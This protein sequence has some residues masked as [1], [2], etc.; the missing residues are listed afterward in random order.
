M[1]IIP[2]WH[3][4]SNL[5]SFRCSKYMVIPN[6]TTIFSSVIAEQNQATKVIVGSLWKTPRALSTS[7]FDCVWD[8]APKGNVCINNSCSSSLSPRWKQEQQWIC[9]NKPFRM[10]H[11]HTNCGAKP[12]NEER[13]VFSQYCCCVGGM[14]WK[15]EYCTKSPAS[16][17][18]ALG[19]QINTQIQYLRLCY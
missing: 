12:V 16:L 5:D 15:Q 6:I 1:Y 2:S 14:V 17:V 8:W 19:F 3:F 10:I 13:G 9:E 7:V 18:M 11:L 4:K